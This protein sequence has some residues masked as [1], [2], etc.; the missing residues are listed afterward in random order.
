VT[1]RAIPPLLTLLLLLSAGG[2]SAFALD[3]WQ[4][5]EAAEKNALFLDIRFSAVSFSSGFDLFYPEFVLEYLPPLFLPFSLGVYVKTPAPN[6]KSFGFR[7]GY[8]VNLGDDKTDLYALYVFEC[9]WLRKDILERYGDAAPPVRH[10]D[11]RAGL[12]RRIGK[13]LCLS[14]ESDFKFQGVIIGVSLKLH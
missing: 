4:H 12:R 14:L 3:I 6:L 1:K 11:F 9:G 2:P 8:H 7:I 13:Y 10:Y 5:P